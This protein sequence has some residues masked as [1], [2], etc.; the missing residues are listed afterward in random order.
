MEYTLAEYGDAF[1]YARLLLK[2]LDQVTGPSN[3]G[4][5]SDLSLEIASH[6]GDGLDE[7]E[8][9]Q[10]LQDDKTG[11]VTHYLISQL[12]EMM[13]VLAEQ[14]AHAPVQISTLF[15][16]ND[17]LLDDWRPLLRLLYRPGDPFS[18]RGAALCLMYILQAGCRE[19]KSKKIAMVE[20]TLQS[21]VSWLTSRLQS[22]H[23]TSLGVVTPTLVVLGSCPAARLVFDHA[24]GIG[25]LARHLRP[26][27]GSVTLRKP[28]VTTS[29]V[30]YPN[31]LRRA[32][33]VKGGNNNASNGF[34][35]FFSIPAQT[36][37]QRR[38]SPTSVSP[39]VSVQQLYELCFCLWTM[40]YECKHNESIKLHFARD[41][42]IP[43][44]ADL[45]A[46]AP[47]EK[48]VRLALASL[49]QL[50][51]SDPN[52]F[53]PEM[54]ACRVLKSVNL[55]REQKQWSDPDIENDLIILHRL[56]T[57]SQNEMTK[58]EVYL[59]ELESGHLKWGILHTEQFF[60]GNA[61][62]LE[63]PKSDFAPV[64]Q[65][66]QLISQRDDDETVAVACY[67][68]GEFVRFYPNGKAIAKRLGVKQVV[69]P[70]LQDHD[71]IEI[72]RQALLCISKLL[73]NNWQ[74]AIASSA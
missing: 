20:E 11:V 47:R 28:V 65:L 17:R 6:L 32:N 23:S 29:P 3:P 63:G 64:K 24:G 8:S 51:E 2:V 12:Y 22:S 70:L 18:Q 56:L 53:V 38:T 46:A 55:L 44:L 66:I 25:Y 48:V 74:A 67:D 57:A 21:L 14:P 49:R 52:L 58:W 72:Q 45:I 71:N 33:G 60:K 30:T 35:G 15:Y 31:Y 41:G 59:A 61:R 34:A 19:D 7:E 9:L 69:M 43:A 13:G 40:T 68:L 39:H 42:A 62:K 26:K 16:E 10:V 50:A 37:N 54:I 73:V 5:V 4:R 27:T 36:S 1:G